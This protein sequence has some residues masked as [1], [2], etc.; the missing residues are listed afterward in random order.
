VYFVCVQNSDNKSGLNARTVTRTKMADRFQRGSG[1]GPVLGSAA[2]RC[3]RHRHTLRDRCVHR[4]RD[5]GYLLHCGLSALAPAVWLVLLHVVV[6]RRSTA[7]ATF[8]GL[9]SQLSWGNLERFRRFQYDH[10]YDMNVN[11]ASTLKKQYILRVTGQL[12]F[13]LLISYIHR[14]RKR[15]YPFFYF[16]F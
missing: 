15:L 3:R 1:L 7:V 14:V 16:F 4:P 12:T 13:R 6:T 11:L 9:T 10:K 8:K 2:V 5:G